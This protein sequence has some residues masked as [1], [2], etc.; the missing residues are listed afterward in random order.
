MHTQLKILA[1]LSSLIVCSSVF[2]SASNLTGFNIQ[3]PA[4]YA[5]RYDLTVNTTQGTNEY[6]DWSG[7][8][9]N[10]AQFPTPGSVS[11]F[12]G[13]IWVNSQFLCNC[14]VYNIAPAYTGIITINIGPD[15]C[16]MAPIHGAQGSCRVY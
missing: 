3:A 6:L 5:L 16:T 1:V 7:D 11:S 8:L 10:I 2:A 9:K 13:R 15:S 12:T 4:N 14:N